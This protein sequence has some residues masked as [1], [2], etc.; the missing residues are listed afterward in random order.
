VPP[1][2]PD[3]KEKIDVEPRSCFQ[4]PLPGCVFVKVIPIKT[5]FYSIKKALSEISLTI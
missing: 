3:I 1:D 5:S 4:A 2:Y